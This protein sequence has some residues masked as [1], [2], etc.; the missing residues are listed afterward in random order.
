M[1]CRIST[2][3]EFYIKYSE[4]GWHQQGS[5]GEQRAESADGELAGCRS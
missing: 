4:A 3:K 2:I 1:Y 5:R